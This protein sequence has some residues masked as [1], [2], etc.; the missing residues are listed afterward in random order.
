MYVGKEQLLHKKSFMIMIPGGSL[1][2]PKEMEED[3]YWFKRSSLFPNLVVETLAFL[4]IQFD[5]PYRM[6]LKNNVF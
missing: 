2:E 4:K 6:H 1:S 5:I 3:D